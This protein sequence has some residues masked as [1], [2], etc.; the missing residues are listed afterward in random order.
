MTV[1][2]RFKGEGHVLDLQNLCGLLW[3]SLGA[4]RIK[5]TN[6]AK[7]DLKGLTD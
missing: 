6:Q 2:D 3:E 1:L 7:G 5:V 4:W